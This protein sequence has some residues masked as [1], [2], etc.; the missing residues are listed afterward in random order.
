MRGFHVKVSF[1]DRRFEI[2]MEIQIGR[3][4]KG[5]IQSIPALIEEMNGKR[6]SKKA[7]L[8]ERIAKQNRYPPIE[9]EERNTVW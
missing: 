2:P 6:R 4:K 7:E 3:S 1:E 9:V 8:F 5:K